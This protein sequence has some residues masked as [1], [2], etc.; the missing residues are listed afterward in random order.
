MHRNIIFE[1]I[2]KG[3]SVHDATML[4]VLNVAKIQLNAKP[5]EKASYLIKTTKTT[6]EKWKKLS[7]AVRVKLFAIKL[8]KA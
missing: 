4:N 8:E 6:Q 5:L 1:T 3:K 7:Q 2:F